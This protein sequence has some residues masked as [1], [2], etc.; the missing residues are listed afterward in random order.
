M[1]CSYHVFITFE[2]RNTVAHTAECTIAALRLFILKW[3]SAILF[4][5]VFP[6]L[7]QIVFYFNSAIRAVTKAFFMSLQF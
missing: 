3:N 1:M 5:C 6:L 2:I 4:C 7:K